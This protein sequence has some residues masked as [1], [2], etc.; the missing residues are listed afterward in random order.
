VGLA[1][2]RLELDDGAVLDLRGDQIEIATTGE[3]RLVEDLPDDMLPAE[4]A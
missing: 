2:L 3:G 4:L 1:E